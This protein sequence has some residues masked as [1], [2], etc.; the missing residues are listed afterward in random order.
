MWKTVFISD[1]KIQHQ[2]SARAADGF[3]ATF[4][5]LNALEFSSKGDLYKG[6]D[7]AQELLEVLSMS[8]HQ[9]HL[10]QKLLPLLLFM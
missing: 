7:S 4:W 5:V 8:L 1:D 2:D 6:I 9:L 10:L 3:S